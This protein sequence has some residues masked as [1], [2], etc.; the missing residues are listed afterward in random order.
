MLPLFL[1][2]VALFGPAV[3]SLLLALRQR[4]RIHL[5]EYE[6]ARLRRDVE[7]LAAPER[8]DAA[9]P[10]VPVPL[11]PLVA[12]VGDPVAASPAA[13]AADATPAAVSSPAVATVGEQSDDVEAAIGERW[14]LYAGVVVLLLAVTFF[15]RYAFDRNWLSPVVRVVLGGAAGV[16]LGAGGV[17]LASRGYRGYGLIVAGSGIAALYLSTYAAL[18]FYGLIAPATAFTLLAIISAA[19]AWV[20]D[21]HN[22]PPLAVVAVLGGF[23]TPFLVGGGHDAQL[24]L[25]TY[26]AILIAA[27][28]V[29]AVRRDWWYLDVLSLVLTMATVAAWLGDDYSPAKAIRTELFLTLYCAMFLV[30]LR[31]SLTWGS[32]RARDGAR[33]LLVAPIAYHAVSIALLFPHREAFLVYE[34]LATTVSLIVAD[35]AGGAVL[36]ACAWVAVALPLGA[37]LE[38][39]AG[40]AIATPFI[41]VGAIYVVH[42]AAQLHTLAGRRSPGDE[43][44]RDAGHHGADIAVI[45]ANGL[46]LYAALAIM[47]ERSHPGLLAPIAAVLALWNGGLAAAIVRTHRIFALHVAG[48]A[49]TLTAMAIAT[50]FD[51]PWVVVMWAMESAVIVAI[52]MHT[53]QRWFRSAGWL[54]MIIA[55]IRWM[56]PD[57]QAT[58][59]SAPPLL[60]SRTLPAVAIIALLYLLAWLTRGAPRDEPYARRE[61]A[62]ALLGASALTVAVISKE[63]IEYW[64]IRSLRDGV[65]SVA[66]ESMLS[67]AWAVYAA[68]AIAAGI[69]RRY[70]PIRYFAIALFALTLLKV[71]A[72]DLETLGGIYRIAAFFIVGAVLLFA[73]FLYQKR[74]QS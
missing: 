63:I 66:R 53:G 6:V 35:R 16:A 28:T 37:W 65:V 12:A 45:H 41:A 36:R 13:A 40:A 43:R 42:L 59:V 56:A 2:I 68:V 14:L 74:R 39:H 24:N 38:A 27:T 5:L 72:V 46:G 26:V 20:A 22:A 25:F 61:R 10:P 52:A 17:R 31:A 58:A 67:A 1:G 64:A 11:P 3:A 29:L 60:N 15:L 70:A 62:V 7:R 4:D 71:F 44:R 69:R 47:L 50:Q 51:G 32:A 73:S 8:S 49:A 33:L 9:A 57:V 48:V 55:V 19:S 54:L 23:A 34:I 18:A 30:I 21:R